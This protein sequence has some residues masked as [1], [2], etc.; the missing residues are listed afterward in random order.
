LDEANGRLFTAALQPGRFAAID[1]ENGKVVAELP[2]V[3]GVDDLWFDATRKRI[4]ASGSG[5]IDVFQQENPDRYNLLARVP[6]GIGSGST[7]FYLKTRTQD[8]MF[9]S[10]P[11]MLPQGGSEVLL[12]Y[13]ND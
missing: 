3:L 7:S 5:A 8:G 11:N 10:W 1:T 4:Y 6:V 2:C 13:V 12:F 9:L